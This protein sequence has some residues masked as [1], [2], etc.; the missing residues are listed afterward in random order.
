MLIVE[1]F[2]GEDLLSIFLRSVM[3]GG[4]LYTYN[5]QVQHLCRG[6]YSYTACKNIAN[7]LYPWAKLIFKSPQ[8]ILELY[9]NAALEWYA[10][11]QGDSEPKEYRD[12]NYHIHYCP[13]CLD[14]QI[15][16]HGCR[17]LKRDWMLP[18]NRWCLKHDCR[19]ERCRKYIEAARMLIEW[20]WLPDKYKIPYGPKEIYCRPGLERELTELYQQLRSISEQGPLPTCTQKLLYVKNELKF[21]EYRDSPT[22]RLAKV[23]D[24]RVK[25]TLGGNK[26]GK[27][28]FYSVYANEL[29]RPSKTKWES[30]WH[31]LAWCIYF[32]HQTRLKGMVEDMLKMPKIN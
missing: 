27:Y 15:E 25:E 30:P 19:M 7:L 6:L 10:Q 5:K 32:G 28:C 12:G 14:E 31:L 4:V 1:P 22:Y 16:Q 13:K 17:Y 11:S 20:G 24:S 29:K 23:I 21:E 26:F 9:S 3:M 18:H 8:E 2:E